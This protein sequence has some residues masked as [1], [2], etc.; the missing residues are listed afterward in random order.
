MKKMYTEMSSI[1]HGNIC[2][3]RATII[4]VFFPR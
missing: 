3:D 1:A 2:E 4:R